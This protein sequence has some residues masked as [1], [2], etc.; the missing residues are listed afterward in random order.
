M[1][2]EVVILAAGQGSRMRSKRPKVL[3]EVAG[4]SMLR[5]V[6]DVAE[7]MGADK[8]HI[9]I[10]H[11]ASV[12]KDSVKQIDVLWALQA[13][14]KGTGHAV[15]Q[16]LP[17]ISDKAQVLILYGDVPLISPETIRKLHSDKA[18]DALTLLTVNLDDPT[19]Y[20]RII[21][22]DGKKVVAIVEQKDATPEQ[23]IV[24]EV[25]TGIMSASAKN[26]KRWLP[27]LQAN[28]AQG[29]YYLTDIVAM[30]VAE[31]MNINVCHASHPMEVQGANTRQQLQ[32]LERYY[33][34][35]AADMLMTNGA[36]LADAGR[37]DIRG[38][39][40]T[41]EDVF[42][43]INCVFE[44]D[45]VLGDGV[46]IGP[47]CH[48]INA[49]IAANCEVKSNSVIEGTV[50]AEGCSIG[51]FARLRPGTVLANGVKIGN[52]VET[53]KA[54]IGED[55]KVSHL[56]YIG[57]A[58]IGRDVNVGAGT[59]TCNYDGV[60]KFKTEIADNAF[61]GSNTALVAPVSVGK[62]ATIG[63]GSTITGNIAEG[64]LAIARAKQRNI[65]TWKR[66]VKIPR[67]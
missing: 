66:P 23:L 35:Q 52:F 15:A 1:T 53:K 51:P 62:N 40:Q 44:G 3:H 21:R 10:G 16:A 31:N 67:D 57:D 58:E 20:G 8:T 50:V 28:N 7:K 29:E 61:V 49:T 14:Q 13:E 22:D 47:N 25:N 18:D 43:D 64:E 9:V 5:H 46:S 33:Q 60:N 41:G 32:L 37:I 48:I 42:I 26:L 63:A 65:S 4:K 54:N 17:A 55:S 34:Q 2:L 36:T 59:I 11:G 39:L 38:T 19:G 27:Q 30:A 6:I 12:V 24:K 56:S 45:V